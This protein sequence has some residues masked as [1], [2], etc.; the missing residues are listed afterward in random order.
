MGL[1][2]NISDRL[3]VLDFGEKI[4]EGTPEAMRVV[5]G[6][7]PVGIHIWETLTPENVAWILRRADARSGGLVKFYILRGQCMDRPND[8]TL[9]GY[10]LAAT[11][12]AKQGAGPGALPEGP[13]A[14][15]Y[16]PPVPSPGGPTPGGPEDGGGGPIPVTPAPSPACRDR[17]VP[18]Q[19]CR[20]VRQNSANHRRRQG[21]SPQAC[22]RREVCPPY[23]SS[24][25]S[26][27]SRRPQAVRP[28]RGRWRRED[29]SRRL[30]ARLLARQRQ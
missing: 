29:R 15:L 13:K 30:F 6:D 14:Q 23:P 12:T 24:S 25:I 1:V 10:L 26:N 5:P 4:A 9:Y 2:M 16:G 17:G 27:R 28:P 22:R 11:N 21:A 19:A 18:L 8:E 3:V 7:V 20:G